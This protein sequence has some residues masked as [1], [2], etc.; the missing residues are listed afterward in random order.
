MATLDDFKDVMTATSHT[1]HL[2]KQAYRQLKATMEADQ[3]ARFNS[4]NLGAGI[5]GNKLIK[6]LKGLLDFMVR[7]QKLFTTPP[8]KNTRQS[9]GSLCH[10]TE[11]SGNGPNGLV[12]D[13]RKRDRATKTT[14]FQA[15]PRKQRQIIIETNQEGIGPKRHNHA[16]RSRQ[17]EYPSDDGQ[18]YRPTRSRG[19]EQKSKGGR[20]KPEAQR[21]SS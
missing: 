21:T 11:S 3:F 9:S 7:D 16:T 20:R 17:H 8:G 13:S 4:Y 19:G 12:H 5:A 15:R 18:Q 2:D 1:V 10:T 6:T 14:L